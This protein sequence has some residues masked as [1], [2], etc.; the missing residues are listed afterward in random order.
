MYKY[1]ENGIGKVGLHD[2]RTNHISYADEIFSVDFPEGFYILNKSEPNRSGKAKMQ[3]HIIDE[4]IDGISVYI[5]KKN[6]FGKVI[7]EDWTDTFVSAVN[8][9][10]FEFEFVN[11][12]NGYQC[13]LFKGYVWFD[14]KPYHRECEIELHTDQI[15]YMW[16]DFLLI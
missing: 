14:K 11:T 16:N 15:T 10:T 13:I 9:E 6:V 12:Y 7:R 3:C 2:C 5:Y 1:I 8:D 4:D